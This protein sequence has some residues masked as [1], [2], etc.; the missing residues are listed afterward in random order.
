ML[1][2]ELRVMVVIG[3]MS[4]CVA[5]T[6]IGFTDFKVYAQARV[7]SGVTAHSGSFA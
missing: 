7:I 1:L 2:S 3:S 4:L 6:G 5:C